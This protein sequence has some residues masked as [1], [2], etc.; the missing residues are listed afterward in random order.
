MK[1]KIFIVIALFLI[2]I[3]IVLGGN[4]GNCIDGDTD[5]YGNPGDPSCP[6]GPETD[7]DDTDPAIYPGTGGVSVIVPTPR[8]NVNLETN[9]GYFC[10]MP[11]NVDPNTLPQTGKPNL[12]FKYDLFEFMICGIDNGQTVTVTITLPA[13]ID[14][15]TEYWKYGPNGDP[16]NPG[17]EIA[18]WY[19]I[20][21]LDNDG[22]NILE[23][24]LTDG[25]VGDDD[26]E[27]DTTIIDQGGP[28]GAF[29]A[30]SPIMPF[31]LLLTL[32]IITLVISLISIKKNE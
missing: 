24:E 2:S 21:L 9:P 30:M 16:L 31:W 29:G 12:N 19:Q 22:D 4:N 26:G 13:P 18:Y 1:F 23:I 27:V 8:G 20:P 7:C 3:N 6:N 28:G 5:G 14:N 11:K 25:G 17:S 10:C 15:L 32:S